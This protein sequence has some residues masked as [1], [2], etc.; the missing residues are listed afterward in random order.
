MNYDYELLWYKQLFVK[1]IQIQN[2]S[3][4]IQNS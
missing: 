2:S 1:Q 3:F 4:R